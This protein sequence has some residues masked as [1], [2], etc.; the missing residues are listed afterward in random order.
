M[1][2]LFLLLFL[3]LSL[4][5]YSQAIT[6]RESVQSLYVEVYKDDKLLG[7]ATG[8]IIKSKTQ[9]YLVTNYHVV[10]GRSPVDRRWLNPKDTIKP[11]KIAILHNAKIL[12]KNIYKWEE[13]LDKNGKPLWRENKIGNEMVDV[14][15]LPLKDTSKISI[16]PVPYKSQLDTLL[17]LQ[18]MDRVF[19]LGFPLGLKSTPALPIWKSGLL[20]SEPY[21]DQ[22]NKP[23]V[24]IDAITFP[25][26]SGS[27]VYYISNEIV[28]KNGNR[29]MFTNSVSI[30][31]GVFSHANPNNVYGAL[32][33]ASFLRTIFDS[34]P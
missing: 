9:N 13:L 30:F 34:L 32:W 31:M 10:T 24:W 21:I 28:D 18:P 5:T 11:N 6:K 17:F 26:M 19:I 25:G 3:H 7:S 15:E 20:A 12:G 22:E 33:K 2:I 29:N 27:P 16:Y 23:I 8:F 1:K 4:T 14:V